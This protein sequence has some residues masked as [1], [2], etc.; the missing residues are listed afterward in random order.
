[1]NNF[2][3]TQFLSYVDNVFIKIL[4]AIMLNKL[5]EIS[6]FMNDD[7]YNLLNNRIKKL[8]SDNSI[9]IY[10]MTNVKSSSIDSIEELDDKY[11]IKVRLSSKFIEYTIDKDT[12]KKINGDTN[13]RVEKTYELIFEKYKDSMDFKSNRKCPNCGANIDV[14]NNGK[15]VYCGTTYNLEDYYWILTDIK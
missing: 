6:H 5:D 4:H 12:K 9:Q 13:D 3:E 14:N 7:V 10:E 2:N 8:N 1:M 11:R 15:C